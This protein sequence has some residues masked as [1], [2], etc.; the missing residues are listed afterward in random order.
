MHE[1]V[2]SIELSSLPNIFYTW[3]RGHSCCVPLLNSIPTV[4]VRDQPDRI[5]IMQLLER[6]I[7]TRQA[8][9]F[10]TVG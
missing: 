4:A 8:V 2:H 5:W 7:L 3:L 10:A 1:V 9:S 6:T